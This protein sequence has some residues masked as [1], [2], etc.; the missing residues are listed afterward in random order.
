M[1]HHSPD[2]VVGGMTRKS[3][4]RVTC[5]TV[6]RV[7]VRLSQSPRPRAD[8]EKQQ[9]WRVI[10]PLQSSCDVKHVIEGLFCP[11]FGHEEPEDL[12]CMVRSF[13]RDVSHTPRCLPTGCW[14]CVV[15]VQNQRIHWNPE[16]LHCGRMSKAEPH[17]VNR[18]NGWY[19][20]IS[21]F[22]TF[23]MVTLGYTTDL[24]RTK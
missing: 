10:I 17:V 5:D 4:R 1:P 24:A 11:I 3:S 19:W 2:A 15:G 9:C 14:L 18:S 21:S 12:W 22:V 8:K 7:F 16:S 23:L 6:W 13:Y 20:P